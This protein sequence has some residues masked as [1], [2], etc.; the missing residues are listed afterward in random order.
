[1]GLAVDEELQ[2]TV[3]SLVE[4]VR[5]RDALLSFY[6]L[7]QLQPH[8]R[9]ALSLPGASQEARELQHLVLILVPKTLRPA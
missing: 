9:R 4:A 1:M 6:W 7:E 5:Q 8:G 2:A 3:D